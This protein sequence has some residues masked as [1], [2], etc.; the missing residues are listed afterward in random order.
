MAKLIQP[1]QKFV[2]SEWI[3]GC[4]YL[5]G[6][7][8]AERAA[9]ERLIMESQRTMEDTKKTTER[10]IFENKKRTGEHHFCRAMICI[11]AA[12]IRLCRTSC[13]VRGGATVL[14]VGG[15]IL[16]A[17]RA[18]KNFDPPHFLASGGGQ[19]IA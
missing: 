8:E 3:Y 16:R 11:S 2:P 10:L 15:G 4:R 6:N 18:K 7:A 1:P 17:E 19:N 9:A 5:Y 12:Y 14:K 13:D